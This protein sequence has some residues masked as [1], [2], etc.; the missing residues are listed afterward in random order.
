[1]ADDP[2]SAIGKAESTIN[3]VLLVAALGIGAYLLYQVTQLGKT[4]ADAV[5]SL[6][7]VFGIGGQT[8]QEKAADVVTQQLQVVGGQAGG[9][10]GYDKIGASGQMWSCTGG[11]KDMCAPVSV[12]GSGNSTITGAAV[13]AAQAN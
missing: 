1:M 9:V 5:T 11:A 4:G 3:M 2:I 10:G 8:S 13:P 6:L 12:D 7:N